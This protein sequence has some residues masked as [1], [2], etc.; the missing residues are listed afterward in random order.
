MLFH[1]SGRVFGEWLRH[2]GSWL[3]QDARHETLPAGPTTAG[4]FA[5]DELSLIVERY[6]GYW[7]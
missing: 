1:E 6:R 3:I 5:G 7:G 4:L 2:Q